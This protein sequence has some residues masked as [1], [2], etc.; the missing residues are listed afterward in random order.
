MTEST[1]KFASQ[2]QLLLTIWLEELVTILWI[3]GRKNS[4]CK[5]T[6]PRNHMGPLKDLKI[7]NWNTDLGKTWR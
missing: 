6:E 5:G 4:S 3:L 7:A 2:K 1:I